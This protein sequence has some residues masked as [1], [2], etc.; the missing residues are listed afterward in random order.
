[1]LKLI[2]NEYIKIFKRK[3][4]YIML[5]L[6]LLASIGIP[7]LGRVLDTV[8]E[9]YYNPSYE[10]ELEYYSKDDPYYMMLKKAMELNIPENEFFSETYSWRYEA[11]SF[12]YYELDYGNAYSDTPKIDPIFNEKTETLLSYIEAN[13]YKSFF[14]SMV[15]LLSDDKLLSTSAEDYSIE[16]FSDYKS[17]CELII[18]YD[19][20]PTVDSWKLDS[21]KRLSNCKESYDL[22][23]KTMKEYGECKDTDLINEKNTYLTEKYRIE[24]NIEDLILKSTPDMYDYTDIGYSIHSDFYEDL[25]NGIYFLAMVLIIII[26]VAGGIISHEFNDGTIKFLLINPVSRTKIFWSK[27][28]TLITYTFALTAS[29]FGIQFVM[30]LIFNGGFSA[31]NVDYISIVDDKINASSAF[32]FII[33]QYMYEFIS[34]IITA[35]IAFLISSLTKNSSLSIALSLLLYFLYNTLTAL[36]AAM[37]I[38]AFKY[39][40]FANFD[41]KAII[42]EQSVF[43]FHTPEF[44]IIII[45]IHMVVFLLTAHDAFKLKN[46]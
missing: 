25:D 32:L 38:Y 22:Y 1:L 15:I 2:K 39:T 35:T 31:L 10:E 44:A 4:T 41:L 42:N 33:T 14:E 5:S 20:N 13:D 46:V 18:E 6:L 37:N 9:E 24:N 28:L 36:A 26:I 43:Q 30:A 3:S 11:L 34:M 27:Y 12:I 16:Y 29:V 40:I 45:T 19:I 21:I 23:N 7:I 17:T 8:S